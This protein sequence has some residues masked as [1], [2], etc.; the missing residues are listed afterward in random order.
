MFVKS[1]QPRALITGA[2]GFIGQRLLNALVNAG[3]SVRALVRGSGAA[4]QSTP[5]VSAIFGDLTQPSSLSGLCDDIE[6]VYHLAGYAHADDANM[7]QAEEI[8][9]RIT[10]DGTRAL[11]AEARRAGVRR[12]VFVSSIK[13]M[14]EGGPDCLDETSVPVPA[15]AYGRAKLAAEQLVLSAD[16]DSNMHAC[17]LRLP[18]VYGSGGKGNLARMIAAVDCGRF[19]PLPAFDNKRSMVHVDDVVQALRLAGQRAGSAGQTYIVTDGDIYSTNRIIESIYR[20][21]DRN[22]PA[23][24][25]PMS[26]LR[27]GARVGDA[28]GLVRGRPFPFNSGSFQ[29]LSGS[30]W[31]SSAKI[32]RDL[33]FRSQYLLETALPEM[34]R[35]YRDSKDNAI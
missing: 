5:T 18:L 13:A 6:V 4:V 1:S 2:S 8:H 32:R 27:L 12:V 24:A 23:R 30:A 34:I 21:L 14:G 28:I 25:I 20:A 17:V 15:S 16:G 3:A 29:K 9:R 19:P 22:I 31:Y 33:G 7:P 11:L 26:V 35:G 10:V